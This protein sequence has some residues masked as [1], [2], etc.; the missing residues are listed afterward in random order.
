[1]SRLAGGFTLVELLVVIAIMSILTVVVAPKILGSREKAMSNGCLAAFHAMDGEISNRISKYESIGD[2][3]GATKSIAEVVQLQDS[4][5]ANNPRN[6]AEPGYVNA[7]TASVAPSSDTSC[8]VFLADA[9][10]T[11]GADR[12]PTVTLWQ[13]E[14]GAIRSGRIT[15]N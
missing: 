11:S 13:H 12:P 15:L 10:P 9:T 8:Q 7:G 6:R 1:V 2:T 5:G 4:S 14:G 3:Q